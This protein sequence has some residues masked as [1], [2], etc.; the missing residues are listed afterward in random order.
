MGKQVIPV[1]FSPSLVN[2]Q[3]PHN[4][5]LASITHPE[6]TSTATGSI[7]NTF[8]FTVTVSPSPPLPAFYNNYDPATRTL[9]FNTPTLAELN[10]YTFTITGISV[11]AG[12]TYPDTFTIEIT[13]T[14]PF[15]IV[16]P[17]DQRVGAGQIFFYEL[18]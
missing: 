2:I 17:L 4:Q 18:S 14:A 12:V 1:F 8:T 6:L 3:H 11:S 15:F 7:D 16:N 5:P 10:T 9:S 13:N